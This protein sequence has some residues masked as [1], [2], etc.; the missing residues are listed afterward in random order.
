MLRGRRGAR[1]LFVAW[2]ILLNILGYSLFND[3]QITL[4]SVA[5]SLINIV[6]LYHASANRFFAKKVA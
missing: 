6:C 4:L 2:C 3:I 1:D 5:L